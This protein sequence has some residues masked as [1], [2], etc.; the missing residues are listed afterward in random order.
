[1]AKDKLET[2]SEPIIIELPNGLEFGYIEELHTPTVQIRDIYKTRTGD[3][4]C[5]LTL[6]YLEKDIANPVRGVR[7]NLNSARARKDITHTIRDRIITIGETFTDKWDLIIEDICWRA[8]LHFRS[9]TGIEEITPLDK[10]PP[11][12]FLIYPILPL[13]QPAIIFGQ[14]GAGKGHVALTLAILAQL[15]YRDN[16]LQLTTQETPTNVLYADYE[17][18]RGDFVRVLSGL[19]KGFDQFV[20]IHRLA[21]ATP[22]PDIIDQLKAEIK[23]SNIGLLIIDSLGYAAGGNINDAETANRYNLALRQLENVT[24]LTIAH[25]SKDPLTK[26]RSVFGSVFFSNYARSVWEV[27]RAYEPN[28]PDM[29]ITLTHTKSN[30]RYEAPIGLTYNFDGEGIITIQRSEP[31]TP[32]GSDTEPKSLGIV[33]AI[34]RDSGVVMSLNEIEKATNGELSYDYVRYCVSKLVD[35]GDASRISRGM[36]QVNE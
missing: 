33:K 15:P 1:M 16:N 31:A 17:A 3:I 34:L 22:L 6:F 24:T 10:I 30:R 20:N 26:S 7:F 4:T 19:C 18:D 21:M 13:H 12:A 23:A 29:P 5:E 11:P 36:Y 27:K 28:S 9:V 25:H 2:L 35:I 14:G 32:E 8:L